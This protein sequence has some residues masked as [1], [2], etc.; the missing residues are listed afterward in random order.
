MVGGDVVDGVGQAAIFL[1]RPRCFSMAATRTSN[2]M[3]LSISL[4]SNLV[5]FDVEAVYLCF[6]AVEAVFKFVNP[7]VEPRFERAKVVFGRHVLDDVAEHFA[8]FFGRSLLGRPYASSIPDWSMVG[9]RSRILDSSVA[10]I[11]K[12]GGGY[13]KGSGSRILEAR[14]SLGGSAAR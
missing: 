11:G 12:S 2:C 13:W 3:R 1:P 10:E 8:E 9:E 5:S 6:N 4:S 14:R 7:L